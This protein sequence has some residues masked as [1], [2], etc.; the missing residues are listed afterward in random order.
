MKKN[1][2]Q[3]IFESKHSEIPSK[4]HT[5]NVKCKKKKY[6]KLFSDSVNYT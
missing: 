6:L 4:T 3:I 2:N 5:S 1:F